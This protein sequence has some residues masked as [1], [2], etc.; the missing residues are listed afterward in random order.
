MD[1]KCYND[2]TCKLCGCITTA[3]QMC[4]KPC[5]KPCYPV[6][7]NKRLWN[8]F[9]VCYNYLILKYKLEDDYFKNIY[10]KLATE[11]SYFN[12]FAMKDIIMED[13]LINLI[14]K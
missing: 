7:M 8:N 12:K 13:I 1:K 4:N 9:K 10:K 11:N 5:D 2:G 14:N 6:M 3:L